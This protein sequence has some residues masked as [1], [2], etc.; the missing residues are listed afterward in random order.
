MGDFLGTGE[1]TSDTGHAPI[2]EVDGVALPEPSTS[3]PVVLSGL[4]LLLFRRRRARL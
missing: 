3:V 4:T 2:F 1:T